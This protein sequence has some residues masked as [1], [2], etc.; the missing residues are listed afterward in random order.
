[1]TDA[2]AGDAPRWEHF[3]RPARIGA[4]PGHQGGSGHTLNRLRRRLEEHL[5]AELE[6]VDRGG[7]ASAVERFLTL[8]ASGWKGRQ[9]TALLGRSD[10]ASYFRAMA[11]GFAAEGRLQVLALEASGRT[12]AMK[13]NVVA[14]STVFYLK[15]A[16]DES[17]SAFSPGAVLER[18]ALTCVDGDIDSCTDADN[19]LL[20]RMLPHRRTITTPLV[21]LR[22]GSATRA[23]ARALCKARDRR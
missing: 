17:L 8:E 23:V 15:T 19:E 21:A 4:E 22:G 5:D 7:D 11:S 16:F 13:C 6:V 2:L 9:G 20:F 18:A 14:G 10:H 12:V 1:V 3:E